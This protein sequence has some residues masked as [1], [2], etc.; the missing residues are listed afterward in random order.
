M[1]KRFPFTIG[2]IG[3]VLFVL[4]VN[5]DIYRWARAGAG[6]NSVVIAGFPLKWYV[7]EW[8]SEPSVM[9]GGLAADVFIAAATGLIVGLVFR[10]ALRPERYR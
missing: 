1:F 7:N 10:R 6:L 2:F 5:L 4:A 3:G 9:W 8:G